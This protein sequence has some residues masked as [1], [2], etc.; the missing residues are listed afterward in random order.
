MSDIHP[1]TRPS[2]GPQG[3]AQQARAA[4]GEVAETARD[5]ARLVA[6]EAGDQ[7]RRLAHQLRRRTAEQAQQQSRRAADAVRQWSDELSAVGDGVKPDSPVHGVVQQV[8][9]RGTRVADYLETEGL[10][11]VVRDVQAFARRRPGL[12]LAGALAAG[13]LVGRAAKAVSGADDAAGPTGGG[14]P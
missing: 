3:T 4:A 10:N 11:G 8:A 7:T 6:R 1:E 5:Q 14:S 13:F 2:T 12:F 9:D